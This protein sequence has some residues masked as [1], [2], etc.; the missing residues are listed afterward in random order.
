MRDSSNIFHTFSLSL[1]SLLLLV[2]G[3]TFIGGCGNPLE[4][5]GIVDSWKDPPEMTGIQEPANANL[6]PAQSFPNRAGMTVPA[7]ANLSNDDLDAAIKANKGWQL[8]DVRESREFAAGHIETAV[9]LPL[10]ELEKNLTRI[11]KDKDIVLIDL[12]GTRAVSA[13]QDLV[14]NGYDQ[15]RVKVL[16]GG[17]QQWNGINKNNNNTGG[18][19][20]SNAEA[21][22]P[23]V[24]ER[25]GGC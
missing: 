18:N 1:I 4:S 11:S 10:G 14:K 17:M 9:N 2:L 20:G 13:W 25:V 23:E 7:T 6:N 5:V 22:K 16:A 3:V 15:T 21:P 8:I 12:N 24:A 19:S